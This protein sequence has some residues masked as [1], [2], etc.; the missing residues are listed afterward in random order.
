MSKQEPMKTYHGSCHC[1]KVQYEVVLDLSQGIRKCNC[2]YCFKTKYQKVFTDDRSLK[3][4]AGESE[5]ADYRAPNSSWAPDTIHHFFCKTCGVQT[6]SRGFLEMDLEPF[7]GW[8]YALNLATLDDISPEEIL[9]A[10]V[11]FEDGLTDN[12]MQAPK[13]TRHL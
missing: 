10:P 8:F 3:I 1:K 2:T 6:F 13:E 5:L 4:T 12:Q 11:I 9:N 7:K